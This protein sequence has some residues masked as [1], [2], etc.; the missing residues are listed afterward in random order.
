MEEM[1]MIRVTGNGQLKLRPDTTRITMTLTGVYREYADAL[2]HSSLDTE[3]LRT[4][5]LPFGFARED[6]KT[7]QFHVDTEYEGYDDH[8]V[9]K[10]RFVGYRYR[11]VCKIEFASDNTRLGKVL[12]ALAHA[13]AEPELQIGYTV[14]DPEAAKNLLLEKAVDDAKAKAEVLAKAAGLKLG[15]IQSIDYSRAEVDFAVRPMARN[16]LCK[17]ESAD[18]AYNL[19]IEPD[20]IAVSDAVTIVW[21]ID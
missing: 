11:H 4:A 9:Y 15:C 10:N 8:G 18:A 3:T 19:D 21:H 14:K 13:A 6:L 12:Y 5:L 20:D 16:M 7:L 1:R 17:A 2:E